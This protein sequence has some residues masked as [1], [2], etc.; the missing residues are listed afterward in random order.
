MVALDGKSTGSTISDNPFKPSA[1]SGQLALEARL[2]SRGRSRACGACL[3]VV[4]VAAHTRERGD[5]RWMDSWHV[6][7]LV[8]RQRGATLAL[9]IHE[10]NFGKG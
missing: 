5:R 3:G 8:P 6:V 1:H 10:Y 2:F 4:W 9:R 7:E